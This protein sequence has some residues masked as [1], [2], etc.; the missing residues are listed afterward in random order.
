M[1]L[2]NSS[3][4]SF[5]RLTLAFALLYTCTPAAMAIPDSPF[6]MFLAGAYPFTVGPTHTYTNGQFGIVGGFGYQEKTWPVGLQFEGMTYR[7]SFNDLANSIAGSD[8][9][10]QITAG[11]ANV[12]WMPDKLETA[13]FK[14]RFISG[15]GVYNRVINTTQTRLI[16]GTCWDPW[17]GYFPCADT[18]DVTTNSKSQTKMGLNIGGSVGYEMAG[19]QEIFVE[20][21]YHHIFTSGYATQ[22]IPVNVGVRW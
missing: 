18:D 21:R 15:F 20:V 10:V 22:F 1:K 11:T 2:K 19:G 4:N 9:Y 12:T 17:Y 13:E 16:G 14:T 7:T 6:T 3:P 5:L 8:G